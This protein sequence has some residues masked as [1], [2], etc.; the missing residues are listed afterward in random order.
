MIVGTAGHVDHGKT[1]LVRA[2]TGVDT[3]RLKEEKERGISIELGFAYAAAPDGSIMGFVDVPGHEKLVRTMLA[4]A[5]GIDFALLVVAADDGVMPQTREHVAILD[6]LGVKRGLVALT[7]IDLVNAERFAAVA[8]EI[9]ALLRATTLA[10]A[11]ILPV[12]AVTHRGVAELREA[13]HAA[14]A[15]TPALG[16]RGRFRLAVDRRFSLPGAG[17]IVTGPV[18][19]GAVSVGDAV[20]VSPAGLRARVRSIHA[21]GTPVERGTMGQRCALN[22]AGD[23]VTRHAIDRGGVVLDPSL[24]APTARIDVTLRVLE[25]ERKALAHWAAVRVHHGAA[26]VAGRVAVL[27][28]HAVPGTTSRSIAPGHTGRAQLVLE[29]PIAAAVG[30]RF[31]VRDAAGTRTLGGGRFLDL[32][33]PQRRRRTPQR[34]EQLDALGRDDACEALAAAIRRWPFIVDV[35]AF[36]RDRALEEH[37]TQSLLAAVPHVRLDVD[38]ATMV[39]SHETWNGIVERC[40]SALEAAHRAHPELPGLTPAQIGAELQP[41]FPPRVAASAIRVLVASGS[42]LSEGGAVRLPEHR[43]SLDDRDRR[44]WLRVAPLLSDTERFRPPRV[45]E[46]ATQLSAPVGD[47]RRVLKALA[48]ERVLIEVAFDRFFKRE[49]VEELAAM[50]V[51]LARAQKDGKFAVWQF[52]DRLGNGRKIAIEILEYFDGRGLTLRDGELRRL[53][54]R[55]LDAQVNA[56]ESSAV[57]GV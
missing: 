56:I 5:T 45:G 28:A 10:G 36:A 13:L 55:R 37:E 9:G 31:V 3:D 21:Q 47:V 29:H 44:S 32:R 40:R 18:M 30:D 43:F 17:T 27:D 11:D 39:V 46:I 33:P 6:L 1:A 57:G 54:P 15:A 12:S 23:G 25:G 8:D 34:L 53:N 50:V 26:D 51:T 2:L 7:K 19:S 49:T 38:D 14:A 41:R 24:H 4:G 48:R 35:T 22:L 20:V 52:R 42:L 16:A